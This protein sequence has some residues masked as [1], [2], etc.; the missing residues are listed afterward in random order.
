MTDIKNIR[1]H[2]IDY[3]PSKRWIKPYLYGYRDVYNGYEIHPDTFYLFDDKEHRMNILTGYLIKY[4]F[5]DVENGIMLKVS[6][7]W[8][9]KR[10]Y[11][12]EDVYNMFKE[13]LC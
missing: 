8:I 10:N 11:N 13:P 5:E 6:E 7:R 12:N 4:I 2:T 9:D 3:L 1:L